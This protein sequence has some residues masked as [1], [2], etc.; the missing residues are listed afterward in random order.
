MDN[1]VEIPV[2]IKAGDISK[3]AMLMT[4]LTSDN[5]TVRS[6]FETLQVAVM[7]DAASAVRDREKALH[8]AMLSYKAILRELRHLR[9]LVDN[10]LH[11]PKTPWVDNDL[12]RPKT[13][14]VDNDLHRPKTPPDTDKDVNGPK[15]PRWF[16]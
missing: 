9:V 16:R 15:R 4:A 11:R 10:D 2:I 12:H 1:D 5:D 7:I 6:A 3:L 14:W 13:P 8:R